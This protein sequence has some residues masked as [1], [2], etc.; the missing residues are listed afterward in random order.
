M[1]GKVVPLRVFKA[2]VKVKLYLHSLLISALC[3]CEHSALR[4]SYFDKE[5]NLL[6]LLGIEP[7]FFCPPVCSQVSDGTRDVEVFQH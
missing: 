1:R 4:S 6:L 5:K 7:R 2:C 3:K